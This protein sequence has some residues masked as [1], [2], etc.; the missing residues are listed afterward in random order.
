MQAHP[1]MLKTPVKDHIRDNQG[2]Y[3]DLVACMQQ[4][5]LSATSLIYIACT[6]KCYVQTTSRSAN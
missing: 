1:R 5:L 2:G 4:E 3:V 6:S